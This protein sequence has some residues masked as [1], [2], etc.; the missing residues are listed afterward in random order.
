MRVLHKALILAI[1]ADT[2]QIALLPLFAEGIASPL[3][4]G[5]DVLVCGV[6][7]RWLGFHPLLLPTLAVEFIPFA[8]LA[9]TWTGC[10]LLIMRQRKT[11]GP[12]LG[13]GTNPQ[14]NLPSSDH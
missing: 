11:D 9:P 6:L 13:K 7:I 3:D 5:L 10:V 1:A 8:D 4:V 12:G 2:V 14:Q